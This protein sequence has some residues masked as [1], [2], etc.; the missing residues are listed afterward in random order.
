MGKSNILAILTIVWLVAAGQAALSATD[1]DQATDAG[2]P[3]DEERP[4]EGGHRA[5]TEEQEADLTM[6]RQ[7]AI[8]DQAQNPNSPNTALTEFQ[9]GEGYRRSQNWNDAQY[10]YGSALKI[11]GDVPG[12][13][14]AD[15]GNVSA[16]YRLINQPS[17]G[18]PSSGLSARIYA[19]LG[20]LYLSAGEYQYAERY[21]T[22]VLAYWMGN[23]GGFDEGSDP[24]MVNTAHAMSNLADAYT[25]Q[26]RFYDSEIL[27][28]R[29]L[30]L[31]ESTYGDDS[32]YIVP[33]LRKLTAIYY[34]QGRRAEALNLQ[35]RIK[36]IC[37]GQTS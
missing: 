19:S 8:E 24:M 23:E 6:L 15:L 34:K 21:Y 17:M 26:G 25:A 30:Q 35:A 5:S 12:E 28:R 9:L 7:Q 10:W 20:Q 27:Y 1:E 2:Q 4:V 11:L 32:Q 31:E 29:A 36:S 18:M 13:T 3:T 16:D 14:T 22:S 33:E 37:N